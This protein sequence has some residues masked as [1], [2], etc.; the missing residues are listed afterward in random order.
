MQET[1]QQLPAVDL[2]VV[3]PTHNRRQMLR[4]TLDALARQTYPA[5]RFEIVI[6]CDGDSDGTY[7][8][9]RELAMPFRLRP[10]A[11]PQS[12]PAT[13]RNNGVARATAPV[14]L[15]LDDDII[16]LPELLAEHIR[17]H[18]DRPNRVVVGRLL[19]DPDVKLA[20]WTAWEQHIFDNRYR[21]LEQMEM[22]VD[23]RKFYSGNVSVDRAAFLAVGG[24]NAAYKRAEDIEL[25]YRL[26]KA[27]A[28]FFFNGRAAGI[29][30]GV[31]SFEAWSRTQY[32]YGRYDVQLAQ[33]E[34]H[35]ELMPIAS[36]F[37]QRNALNRLL[38]RIAVGRPG[39]RRPLLAFAHATARAADR[40][41]L[42]RISRWSYSAM[43]NLCYW[44]G[45][46]DQ[47]GGAERLWQMV[48][49]AGTT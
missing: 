27:G 12:G 2:T 35:K 18:Q 26:Q 49:S 10:F 20:G 48:R 4:E 7:E 16:A 14:V 41:D 46:A 6:M 39:L 8:M 37:R 13:A 17:L 22:P 3:M 47:L 43:A 44:Q 45:V 38:G 9:L 31:H 42:Q 33:V 34:G 19:P 11:Q 24:F 29:H 15:F 5:D 30:R 25:G 21:A 23:G 32:N 40:A 1:E 36:W 28:Q